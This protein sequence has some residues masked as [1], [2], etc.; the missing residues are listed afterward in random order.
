M[1][2]IYIKNHNNTSRYVLGT[3]GENPLF[4]FGINPSTAEPHNLDNTVKSVER[5][6]KHNGYDSFVMLNLY[7]QR[8]TN[9]NDMHKICNECILAEN[10][11]E[12]SNLLSKYDNPTIWAA[13]GTLIDKR[14]YL[15]TCLSEIDKALDEVNCKWITFGN[16]S[17][18]GH[19]HHP[20]YLKTVADNEIFDVTSYIKSL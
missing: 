18:K 19:P 15:K 5:I 13:W 16:K 4:C 2:W 6:A 12:I 14:D 8:A 11:K 10:I 7:P 3:I 1:E 9:P 20:L 17:K